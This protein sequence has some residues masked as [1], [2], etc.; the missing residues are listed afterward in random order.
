M[1]MII[2]KL[3]VSKHGKTFLK[4]II[5]ILSIIFI[6]DYYQVQNAPECDYITKN[7]EPTSTITLT[8][9]TKYNTIYDCLD[10]F[11][12]ENTLDTDN[13][14]KCDKCKKMYVLKNVLYFGI[15]LM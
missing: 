13:S 11:T 6:L 14:W 15:Y 9:D 4:V 3:K 1:I 2:L 5:L 12:N 10:E 7:H 8:L